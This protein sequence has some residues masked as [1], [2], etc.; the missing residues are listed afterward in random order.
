MNLFQTRSLLLTSIVLL[1][2][3]GCAANRP[4]LSLIENQEMAS[5]LNLPFSSPEAE[6]IYKAQID[7]SGQY[8]S[9]IIAISHSPDGNY[10]VVFL[11]ELGMKFFDLEIG[12]NGLII[13]HC[14]ETFRRKGVLN[15]L[16]E[17]FSTLFLQG[18]SR[19]L[20]TAM[21]DKSGK[22]TVYPVKM[23]GRVFYFVSNSS[24]RLERIDKYSWSAKKMIIQ[25]NDYEKFPAEIRISFPGKEVEI[26]LNSFEN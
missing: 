14:F 13:H 18:R 25:L 19:D 4:G 8:Y 17:T 3:H 24:G 20:E 22:H 16:E 15:I 21:L 23:N 2:L 12:S 6:A 1:V 11:N 9:G 26:R 5:S 7:I 10:R